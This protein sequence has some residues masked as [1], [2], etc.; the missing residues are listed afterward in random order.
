MRL[1]KEPLSHFVALG[2]LMF[3]AYFAL[4]PTPHEAPPQPV[5]R[6]TAADAK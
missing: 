6:M 5:I 3:A 2:A 4:R 1:L